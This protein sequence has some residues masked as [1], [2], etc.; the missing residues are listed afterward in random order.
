LIPEDGVYVI[1]ASRYGQAAGTST[2]SFVL[3]LEEAENS[4]PGNS[5]QGAIQMQLGDVMEGEITSQRYARYYYFDALANDIVTIRMTRL[6]SG[7][8]SYLI[9]LDSNLVEIASNDDT[10]ESQNSTIAN[11][12]IPTDG[13]YYIVTTRYQFED[14]STTGRYRLELQSLG[15]AFD[16]VSENVGRISYGTT[17]TGYI[18]DVVTEVLWAFWGVA[19]HTVT[20]SM[21]R[22][23]GDLDPLVELLDSDQQVLTSDDDSGNGVD[24]RIDR[25][26]LTSTGVYYIRAT[27]FSGTD[28]NA[29][30]R[31]SFILVLA[32]RYD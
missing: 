20:I 22:A 32:R 2:G 10:G 28:G 3:T 18:D 16:G 23:D 4:G 25:Y 19:G 15:N 29:N 1:I 5:P 11:F 27:R 9:L 31:G 24:A 6:G 8:D 30:T 17:V 7:L 12:L 13:R 21:T 14:G 26:T